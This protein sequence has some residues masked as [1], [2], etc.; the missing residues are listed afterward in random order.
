MNLEKQFTFQAKL[1]FSVLVIICF[2]FTCPN[3]AQELNPDRT[4]LSVKWAIGLPELSTLSLNLQLPESPFMQLDINAFH[5]G[6]SAIIGNSI[7]KKETSSSSIQLITGIMYYR[8]DSTATYL[9]YLQTTIMGDSPSYLGAY[10][11]LGYGKKS[12]F[13]GRTS[14]FIDSYLTLMVKDTNDSA[15]FINPMIRYG[16][17]FDLLR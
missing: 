12:P 3:L 6:I 16:L 15:L 4:Q 2:V 7:N 13:I 9:H 17:E 10:I 5:P 11:G 8:G 14:L 1:R